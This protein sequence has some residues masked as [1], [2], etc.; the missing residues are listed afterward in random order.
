[1]GLNQ[2]LQ[3]VDFSSSNIGGFDCLDGKQVANEVKKS[4]LLQLVNMGAGLAGYN[5]SI[6]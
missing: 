3:V 6:G 5:I 2:L 4:A 1:M